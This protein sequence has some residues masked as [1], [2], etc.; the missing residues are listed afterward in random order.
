L[1]EEKRIKKS[2]GKGNKKGIGKS[3]GRSAV[4]IV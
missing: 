1:K 3:S 4:G 2:K